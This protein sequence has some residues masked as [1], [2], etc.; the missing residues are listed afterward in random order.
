MIN[1][2]YVNQ[3]QRFLHANGDELVGLARL[4]DA[5]W[6]VVIHDARGCTLLQSKLH[7]FARMYRCAVDGSAEQ[8]EAFYD[9]V[10]S[11]E[12]DQPSALRVNR[13]WFGIFVLRIFLGR[14]CP[15]RKQA[16]AAQLSGPRAARSRARELPRAGLDGENDGV[17]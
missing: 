6:M 2:A 7:D 3:C 10:P 12:Q 14:D 9:P 15:I 16:I 1:K 13:L 4:L 8:I 11:V 5:R 17:K